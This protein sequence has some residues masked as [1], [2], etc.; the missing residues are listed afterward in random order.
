MTHDSS[1]SRL[2]RLTD[3]VDAYLDHRSKP[4]RDDDAF[5]AAHGD[6]RDLL[7]AMMT[8]DP[9]D[10]GLADGDRY[11]GDYR[12]VREIGRGGMGIVFEAIQES[13]GRRVA[14]KVLPPHLTLSPTQVARFRKEAS[15][16]GKLQHDGIVPIHAIGNVAGSHFYAM[17]YVDGHTLHRSIEDYAERTSFGV[18]RG[19]S[20]SAEAAEIAL[21]IAE[22]LAY[23][24]D[25]GVIHRDV[26]PH[27]VLITT[28][29]RVRICDFGLA[30]DD[31]ASAASKTIGGGGTPYYMSPEQIRAPDTIDARTDVFSLGIVLYEM[32]VGTRPFEGKSTEQVILEV[33]SRDIT[34]VRSVGADVPRDLE[35]ICLKAL[36]K[37]REQRYDDAHEFAADLRRFLNHEPIRAKPAATAVKLAKLVR[38][39]RAVSAALAL[40]FC[41]AIGAA[42]YISAQASAQR[43]RDRANAQHSERAIRSLI[44]VA[45][46]T[47]IPRRPGD[48]QRCVARLERAVDIC[49]GLLEQL[50]S[51][52]TMELRQR[53][54]D[55][56]TFL[57]D[58]YMHRADESRAGSIHTRALQVARENLRA[59]PNSFLNIAQCAASFSHGFQSRPKYARNPDDLAEFDGLVARLQEMGPFD[60][61]SQEDERLR[62][63]ASALSWRA[64]MHLEARQS[65]DG[66]RHDLETAR[67]SWQR[68]RRRSTTALGSGWL[69]T[70]LHLANL[71]LVEGNAAKA[72]EIL[73]ATN[74]ELAPLLESDPQNLV[75]RSEAA[76]LQALRARVH[77]ALG[78]PEAAI[79]ASKGAIDIRHQIAEDFPRSTEVTR[80]L[81]AEY[82]ELAIVFNSIRRP[83][84]AV[85]A[86]RAAV[87]CMVSVSDSP[88]TMNVRANAR[89]MLGMVLMHEANKTTGIA[90]A[91]EPLKQEIEDNFAA[92]LEDQ[93]ALTKSAPAAAEYAYSAASIACN[94][95]SWKLALKDYDRALELAREAFDNGMRVKRARDPRLVGS[96]QNLRIQLHM[97][98]TCLLRKGE[99]RQA[100]NA[101]V[102]AIE[103][104]PNSASDYVN[105]AIQACRVRSHVL[106]SDAKEVDT[107]EETRRMAEVAM[108]WLEESVDSDPRVLHKHKSH[109]SLKSLSDREDFRQL[110]DEADRRMTS[111]RN[112]R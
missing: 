98:V 70:N 67:D 31:S 73:D 22:A 48:E 32:L 91:D 103:L 86:A 55:L 24:H 85:A 51:D 13:L 62:S 100:W 84:N 56:L 80:D 25:H 64:T 112:D 53:F 39:H 5:L 50:G 75:L 92:A 26:K 89:G 12:I 69:M 8:D 40:A 106:S 77:V 46:N 108:S 17:E 1:R 60:D 83:K 66:V 10:T 3:A 110:L 37:D 59:D 30:R 88:E 63:V 11:L 43:D 82:V 18:R 29:G 95:A 9:Q 42:I 20:R 109:I 23:S 16:A 76:K 45:L 81:A 19:A 38:R 74:T 34:G 7:E 102:S 41:I 4:D 35:T 105:A 96:N 61:A 52:A 97:L 27:N 72:R 2:S 94:F 47:T 33:T 90:H 54:V 87:H 65:L 49:E 111:K 78:D 93:R 28:D 6:L 57:G 14:L 107:V 58:F 104:S 68:Q 44:D 99:D 79:A 21:R 101:V 36:A 15:A 71:E